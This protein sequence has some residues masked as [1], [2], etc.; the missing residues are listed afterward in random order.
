MR[1]VADLH[2]HTRYSRAT[3][4]DMNLEVLAETA[5]KKGVH[6]LGTGDITHPEWREELKRK[7]KPERAGIFSYDGVDFILAGEVSNIYTKGNK[8]RKIHILLL[9]PDFESADQFSDKIAA[10]G[11]LT[12]DGR[13]TLGLDVENMTEILME[14]SEDIMIIPAHVWTPWFSLFGANSGFDSVEECFGK[15]SDKVTALETGLSSDPPMNWRLSKLDRYAL[16]SNSDAHSPHRIAREANVF[17]QVLDYFQLKDV[18]LRKD[19]QKF[20]FTIEFFPEEGKY[21]YDGHRNC[22]VRLKPRDAIKMG[23]ICPVCGREITIGVLHRVEEL[24]DRPEGFVPEN[25]IPYK[26]L[27]PLEE[28][29]AEALGTKVESKAVQREYENLISEFGDELTVLL[30][31]ERDDLMRATRPRVAEGVMR[32]REGKLKIIPGYDG[33]YGTIKIFDE[34]PEKP[35]MTLF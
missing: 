14:V 16:V 21:H 26:N 13:P 23:N 18:L 35:Q 17:S 6:L 27:V 28:I 5:K 1:Y 3:S 31:V 33:V 2:I 22:N 8:L 10:Y 20:L 12:A 24:A 15:Y 9:F 32:V 25:A 29:I 34:E 4:R 11:S 7:L 19:K 30:D